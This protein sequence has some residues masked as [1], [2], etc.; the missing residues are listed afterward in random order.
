[1]FRYIFASIRNYI[2]QIQEYS[3][4]DTLKYL[5]LL[6]V[7]HWCQI[8]TIISGVTQHYRGVDGH[9][10]TPYAKYTPPPP[11]PFQ[12]LAPNHWERSGGIVYF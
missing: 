11:T 12:F 1:M 7:L 3:S 9:E 4:K 10:S 2:A 6:S 5:C 8:K